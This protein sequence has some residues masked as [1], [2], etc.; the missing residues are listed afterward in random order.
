LGVLDKVRK[1][2]ACADD[3]RL[4]VGY[5]YQQLSRGS[6]QVFFEAKVFRATI[7]SVKIGVLKPII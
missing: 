2:R 4:S 1:N 7:I 5:Q 6:V 3:I